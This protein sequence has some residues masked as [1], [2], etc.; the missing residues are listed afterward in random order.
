M[1]FLCCISLLCIGLH[2]SICGLSVFAILQILWNEIRALDSNKEGILER[3]QS[4]NKIDRMSGKN[5]ME[6]KE[7]ETMR[8][9]TTKERESERGLL[10]GK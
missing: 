9:G 1:L 3:G 6:I 10:L 2:R 7:S 4:K 5:D 8:L